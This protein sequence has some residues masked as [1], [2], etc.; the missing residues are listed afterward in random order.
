M[1]E[2]R[3]QVAELIKA[4]PSDVVMVENASTGVN[5]ILRHLEPP[6]AAGDKVLFLSCA[7]GM[8]Q[9]V[10]RFLEQSAG[11]ELVMVDLVPTGFASS[12]AVIEAVVAK[13]AEHGGPSA[14][15][16]G[17]IS[18]LSSVPAC[19]LPVAR[20]CAALSGVPVFVDGAHAPGN[21]EI[22]VS[23]LGA[24]AYTGNLHKWMY[25]PK[26]T[27]FLWV[28]PEFQKRVVPPVLSGTQIFSEDGPNV[29]ADFEYVGTRDCK[30]HHSAVCM[31]IM[32]DVEFLC[33]AFPH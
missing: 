15:A 32:F 5:T 7:Y 25:C 1:A 9:S 17:V 14:F 20:F 29:A 28:A 11:I 8:T 10:L 2:S 26:G 27:A 18:H 24:V 33:N 19:V 30:P 12:D 6:L 21:I 16:M 13:V 3:A 4:E 23:S 31:Q 22:D